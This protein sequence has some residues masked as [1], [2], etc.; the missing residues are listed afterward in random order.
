MPTF[1]VHRYDRQQGWGGG[2]CIYVRDT[3]LV[4]SSSTCH[5]QEALFLQIAYDTL[6]RTEY[7]VIGCVYRPPNSAV[8]FWQ[9][10]LDTADDISLQ[11]HT[12]PILMGDFNVNILD[13][14]HQS[15]YPH[16]QRFCQ[17]LSVRNVIFSPTRLPTKSCLDLALLPL[18]L[19]DGIQ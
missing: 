10:L 6:S 8:S 17:S 18:V 16:L 12:Q 3:H 14:Q 19:D 4:K 11:T 7:L 13:S 15:Q 2:V 1:R 5:N 9:A